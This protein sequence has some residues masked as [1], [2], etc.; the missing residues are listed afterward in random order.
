LDDIE[1]SKCL[2]KVLQTIFVKWK[3]GP[4]GTN[5]GPV[6]PFTIKEL[7][8]TSKT[9]KN[10]SDPIFISAELQNIIVSGTSNA[11]FLEAR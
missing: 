11:T 7:K 1:L 2:V 10:A 8:V 5:I 3:D 9:T 6:D 4:P